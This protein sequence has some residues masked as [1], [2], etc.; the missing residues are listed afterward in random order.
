MQE[1]DDA[2]LRMR[3]QQRNDT[4]DRGGRYLQAIGGYIVWIYVLNM[5]NF[6]ESVNCVQIYR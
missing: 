6:T 1:V 3:T 4:I 5:N 2:R